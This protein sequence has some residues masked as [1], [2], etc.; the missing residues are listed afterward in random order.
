VRDTASGPVY[1]AGLALL[2]LD[3]PARVLHRADDWVLTPTEPYERIGDVPNVVF[4][5]GAIH[6]T[7]T[8]T[9]RL[10]YGAAD[11][12]IAVATAAVTNLLTYLKD[13]PP[14]N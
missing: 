8:D 12:S 1:R 4:P 5:T 6:D 3:D 10:Y 13:C 11:S 9:V 7:S 14:S 2:D